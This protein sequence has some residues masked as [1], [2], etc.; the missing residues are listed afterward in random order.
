MTRGSAQTLAVR[1]LVRH[2]PFA[3]LLV[4]SS[5]CSGAALAEASEAPT[6]CAAE[7]IEI[8]EAHQPWEGPSSWTATCKAPDGQLREW[9]CSRAGEAREVIC[10]DVPRSTKP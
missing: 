7:Q 1:C 2:A 10:T 5:G 9:F 4:L 3:A 6:G 8:S